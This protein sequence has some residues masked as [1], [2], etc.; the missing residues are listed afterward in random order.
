IEVAGLGYPG[1]AAPAAAGG[2]L[3]RHDPQRPALAAPRARERFR[4]GRAERVEHGKPHPGAD[5]RK[6]QCHQNSDLAAAAAT[7]GSG[8]GETG[9]NR[10]TR[11]VT[12]ST[13]LS[14]WGMGAKGRAGASKYMILMIIR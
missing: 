3:A 12:A 1:A 13:A 6:V 14:S 5:R 9:Y 10:W 2:L 4:I 11:P 8:D 7:A